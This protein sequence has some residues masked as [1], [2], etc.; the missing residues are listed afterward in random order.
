M[1]H[2]CRSRTP[3]EIYLHESMWHRKDVSLSSDLPK[4]MLISGSPL[5]MYRVM[6]RLCTDCV[7][8]ILEV[9]ENRR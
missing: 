9:D 6:G 1:I 2:L 4:H 7:D 3:V 5:L 8:N